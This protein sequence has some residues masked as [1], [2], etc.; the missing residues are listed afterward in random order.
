[1]PL[2][3]A[4]SRPNDRGALRDLRGYF[5]NERGRRLLS[6]SVSSSLS[7][8]IFPA[9]ENKKKKIKSPFSLLKHTKKKNDSYFSS[10]SL[11]ALRTVIMSRRRCDNRFHCKPAGRVRGFATRITSVGVTIISTGTS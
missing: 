2:A 7:T 3:S 1:M 6:T 4:A 10:A 8:I 11:I 9:L 5:R